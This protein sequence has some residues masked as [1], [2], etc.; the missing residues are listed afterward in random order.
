[1]GLAT[2]DRRRL[3]F[4]RFGDYPR[5]V[6]FFAT[7][8]R[9]TEGA[10]RDELRELGLSGV[11]A[12][13]GGVHFCG[14]WQDG[15][16]ACLWSR[17]AV[18]ILASVGE[19]HTP[20]AAALY[21][22]VR[23]IDWL[24]FLTPRH[25]LAVRATGKSSAMNHTLFIA[26]KTKDAV[27]D[28]I[29]DACGQRPSVDLRDPDLHITVHLVRD[30]ATVYVDLSGQP[31]HRRGYRRQMVPAPVKETLAAAVLRLA[32]WDRTRPLIDPMCGSGTF[33]IEAAMWAR[34]IAPG[35][36]RPRF[37]FERWVHYDRASA[38]AFENMRLQARQAIR[39][40]GPMILASD[41]DERAVQ[42][43]KVNARAAGVDFEV[44]VRPVTAIEPTLPP[45]MVVVNPPYG[46]RL[47]CAPGLYREMHDTFAALH[48]HSIVILA[49]SRDIV[50]TVR[51]GYRSR[52]VFNGPVECRLIH[53]EVP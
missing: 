12:D 31:L 39:T 22:A 6:D 20:H 16:R 48:G 26:Q 52:T 30:R 29:R 49:G 10:L 19:F 13:R 53:Y 41:V 21:E 34:N 2:V 17:I 45:G 50:R 35:L 32:G 36:L 9:G 40:D 23:S 3:A 11:R 25:T 47:A 24:A 18:R 7:A 27:I 37:G 51:S 8:A 43:T 4:E 38:R 44:S 28:Q 14:G 1:M 15:W 46:E 42:A 33:P 5:S